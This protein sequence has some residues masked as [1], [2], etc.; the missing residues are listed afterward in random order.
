MNEGSV[1]L[2][3]KPC[4]SF[5]NPTH[6]SCQAI[7]S[8]E[9]PRQDY[10]SRLPFPSPGDLPHPGIELTSLTLAGEYST[11]EPPEKLEYFIQNAMKINDIL[12]Y[13]VGF[14]FCFYEKLYWNYR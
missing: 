3:A 6:C 10:W 12:L 11:T 14:Y 7:L 1:V 9:F 5:C 2:V 13:I 8:M 4:Q